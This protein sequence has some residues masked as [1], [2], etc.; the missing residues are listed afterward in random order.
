MIQKLQFIKNN[1]VNLKENGLT[2]NNQVG[3]T[4]SRWEV[5]IIIYKNGDSKE[6]K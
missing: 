5:R 6:A 2:S 1:K 4:K 3:H